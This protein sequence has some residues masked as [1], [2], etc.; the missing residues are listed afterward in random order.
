M[1]LAV[2]GLGLAAAGSPEISVN[3]AVYD[4]GEVIEGIAVVHTFVLTNVGDEPLTITDIHV[5]WGCTTTSLAKSTIEPGESVDLEVP[6]DSAGFSGK[7]VKKIDIESNDPSTPKFT[8]QLTGTVK[9][10]QRYNIPASD[11]NIS[12]IS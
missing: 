5:S 9:R 1:L 10:S 8:L 2:F 6:F 4:F 11:L 7:M 3:T 12:S